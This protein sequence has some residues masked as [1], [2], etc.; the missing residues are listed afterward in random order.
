MQGW[1]WR[2]LLLAWALA[3]SVPGWAE[4]W[5]LQAQPGVSATA[6]YRPGEPDRDPVLILHG[7]LQ[8]RDFSTV[9]RLAETLADDGY[10]VLTPTLSLGVPDRRQS[11]ECEALHLH[12]LDD[13]VAELHRWVQRLHRATG[14]AVTLI[15]HSAGGHVITRYLAEHRDAP[16][17]RAILI[18]IVP[19]E[20]APPAGGEP[21]DLEAMADYRLGYCQRYPTTPRAFHSYVDWGPDRMLTAMLDSPVPV[22]VVLGGA[23]ERIRPVWRERL[24]SGGVELKVI[25][26]ANHFFDSEHEFDLV[27]RVEAVLDGG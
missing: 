11:L 4:T 1:N 8:T 26:G 6:E 21:A 27:E 17:R 16:L 22:H 18:S 23:D 14:R 2:W 24:R 9:S 13:D 19:P 5:R 7:F 15:G 20:G 10:P 12:R 3:G 25:P